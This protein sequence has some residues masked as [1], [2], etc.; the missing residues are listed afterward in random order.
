MDYLTTED[1][2][3]IIHRCIETVRRKVRQGELEAIDIGGQYLFTQESLEKFLTR[4]K[5]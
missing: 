2:S 5:K 1:I 3:K 4:K